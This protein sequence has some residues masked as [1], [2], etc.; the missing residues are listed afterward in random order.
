MGGAGGSAAVG[1]GH[2]AYV[3][4]RGVTKVCFCLEGKWGTWACLGGAGCTWNRL[5]PLV[6]LPFLFMHY[7][8]PYDS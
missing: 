4:F 6:L 5:F 7:S 2:M 8:H 1:R 3:L